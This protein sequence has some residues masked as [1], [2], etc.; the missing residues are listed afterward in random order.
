MVTPCALAGPGHLIPTAPGSDARGIPNWVSIGFPV[1]SRF[2]RVREM[3][4]AVAI[5]NRDHSAEA[6]RRIAARHKD[7][8]MV[9][10]LLALALVLE[11][12]SRT[13]A[14]RRNGMDR[15]TLCDWVHRY[16]AAGVAGLASRV[17]PGPTPRLDEGQMAALEALV[18]KGPDPAADGVVRWRCAD[19]REQVKRRFAVTVHERTIGKWLRRRKL[20]RLQPRPAHPR[21]D[22]AAQ[23]AFKQILPS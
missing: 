16:N 19:L 2:G 22:L 14:A 23:E 7:A 12:G 6:L 1:R 11:G 20:T 5:T 13:E 21:Q 10:R 15:Q 18:L 4:Q 3:G 17:A 8:E 9:R